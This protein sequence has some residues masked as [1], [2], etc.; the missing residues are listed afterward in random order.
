MDSSK[1][2]NTYLD[3]AVGMIHEAINERLQL[4]TQMKLSN[5][6]VAERDQVISSLKIEI[7]ELKKQS[8]EEIRLQ[9]DLSEEKKKSKQ[10]EDSYHAL[11]N[12]VSHFDNLTNQFND[13]KNQL[14]NKN[15]ELNAK[16]NEVQTKINELQAKDNELQAKNNELE[17]L[18]KFKEEAAKVSNELQNLK[19][20]FDS[21]IKE[22]E[23]LKKVKISLEENGEVLAKNIANLTNELMAIKTEKDKLIDKISSLEAPKKQINITTRKKPTPVQSLPI[24]EEVNVAA[25]IKEN[26]DF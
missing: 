2:V 26:N 14:L 25:K 11:S 9:N 17:S 20:Q 6:L 12:K 24:L 10:W 3:F 19:N 18:R 5:D 13:I 21:K 15:N 23:D 4:K 7:E 16:R 1:Y 22:N 8:T